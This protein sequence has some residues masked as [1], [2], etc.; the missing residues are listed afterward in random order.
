MVF[1]YLQLSTWGP[2][3]SALGHLLLCSH[4]TFSQTFEGS[5][6]CPHFTEKETK[7]QN[8]K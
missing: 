2:P 3:G 6:Y 8:M 7:I 5:T 4:L 1:D